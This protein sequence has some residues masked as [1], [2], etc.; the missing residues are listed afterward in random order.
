MPVTPVVIPI[1]GPTLE[2]IVHNFLS[3]AVKFSNPGAAIFL[4][5][6][7]TAAEVII[8]VTDQGP[9]MPDRH[10][11]NIFSGKIRNHAARPTAGESS[12]GMGLYLTG[13]LARRLGATLTC[14]AT[15]TGGSVFSV[16]LGFSP[17]NL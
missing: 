11:Y 15:P 8:S 4:D 5:L 17:R 10:R 14:E 7:Q 3:N 6:E 12:T 9:G 1:H 2:H 13:E 16:H